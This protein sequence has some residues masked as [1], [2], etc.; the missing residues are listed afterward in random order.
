MSSETLS[1]PSLIRDM[2][3]A[4]RAVAVLAVSV[5]SVTSAAMCASELMAKQRWLAML[6]T[7]SWQAPLQPSAVMPIAMPGSARS[8]ARNEDAAEA[9]QLAYENA[10]RALWLA[11]LETPSWQAP[12]QSSLHAG[13]PGAAPASAGNEEAAKKAAWLAKL[14]KPTWGPKRSEAEAKATWLAKLD[15]PWANV[16]C[17]PPPVAAAE[18]PA[19]AAPAM[20]V[21]TSE[22]AAKAAW[23]AKLD[24]PTRGPKMSEAAAKVA[25]LARLDAPAWGNKLVPEPACAT[26]VPVA[27]SEDAAKAAKAAWLA[28]LN[29]PRWGPG[30]GATAPP[31]PTTAAVAPTTTTTTEHTT[32]ASVPETNVMTPMMQAAVILEE[33]ARLHWLRTQPELSKLDAP[34]LRPTARRGAPRRGAPATPETIAEAS[35]LS[36]LDADTPATPETVA[37]RIRAGKFHARPLAAWSNSAYT[38]PFPHF[39]ATHSGGAQQDNQRRR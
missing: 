6:E 38:R 4:R 3:H 17:A 29:A 13:I 24:S 31:A 16:R 15:T 5:S 39:G 10:A 12:V 19:L 11:K 1:K 30:D 21:A 27:A 25:W 2:V 33:A 28:K 8:S 36:K 35:R 18:V 34:S 14:D 7:P 37:E 9:A 22:A 20:S 23:F 26:P 32:T